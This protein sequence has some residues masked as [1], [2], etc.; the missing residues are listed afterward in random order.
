M[1]QSQ[2]QGI[3]Q[4]RSKGV[5]SKTR[6]RSKGSKD[7]GDGGRRIITMSTPRSIE[8]HRKALQ[9]KLRK[10]MEENIKLK[11]QNSNLK[12]TNHRYLQVFGGKEQQTLKAQR[13]T[14]AA[15]RELNYKVLVFHKIQ[16]NLNRLNSRESFQE[17][18][19]RGLVKYAKKL[20][21]ELEEY[22]QKVVMS[23]QILADLRKAGSDNMGNL[24]EMMKQ[25][26][27][28]EANTVEEIE[29][30]N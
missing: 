26:K 17:K 22:K 4:D 28:K 12:E 25:F 30:L 19:L 8:K 1:S 20:T 21:V 14:T 24:I 7:K 10:A 11:E 9:N 15:N 16:D 5:T 23:E 13:L 27:E 18:N 29:K 2:P 6:G 3:L